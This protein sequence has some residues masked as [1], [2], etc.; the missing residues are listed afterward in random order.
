M[1]VRNH[2]LAA[3]AIPRNLKNVVHT[4]PFFDPDGVK[5]SFLELHTPH[6][7]MTSFRCETL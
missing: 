5:L 3:R 7:S 6:R 1:L 4:T 2:I